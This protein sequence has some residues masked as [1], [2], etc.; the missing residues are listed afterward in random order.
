VAI[1]VEL[2][3]DSGE[4]TRTLSIAVNPDATD[5]GLADAASDA[6]PDDGGVPGRDAGPANNDGSEGNDARPLDGDGGEE[7]D[8]GGCGCGVQPTMPR[9]VPV[10]VLLGFLLRRGARLG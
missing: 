5:G 2:V 7:A 1:T 3:N 4:A 9:L 10:L 6:R 8:A